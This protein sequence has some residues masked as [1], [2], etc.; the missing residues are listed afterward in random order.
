MPARKL[1][2][3]NIAYLLIVI[4]LS[5][6]LLF[7]GKS[8][9]LPL[10]FSLF[11]SM[12][13]YPLVK[14]IQKVVHYNAISIILTFFI[15]LIPLL[16]IAVFF[17]YQLLDIIDN[18][19]AIGNTIKSGF[20]KVINI[21]VDAV[22][23]GNM[24]KRDLMDNAISNIMNSPFEAIQGSL[25]STTG[26]LIGFGLTFIYTFFLLYYRVPIKAFIVFQFRESVRDEV[27][28]IIRSIQ[29]MSESYIIGIFFVILILSIL[30]T[31]GLYIIGIEYAIFWG[32]TA[33]LLAIIPYIGTALGGMLPFLFA[34]STTDTTWQPLAVIGYYIIIQ[35]VEGNF[36]TPKVVGDQVNI[37]P[38]VGLIG[39][40]FFGLFWG[41]AGVLLAIPLLAIIRIVFNHINITMPVGEMMGSGLNQKHTL[42]KEK[43]DDE[44]FSFVRYFQ[45]RK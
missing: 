10:I 34:L 26:I 2:I 44:K 5:G 21:I 14:R 6:F 1:P 19:P 33:G 37:N 38:F 15:V 11:L 7:I 17:S 22:P 20:S 16:L 40:T 3:Q 13:L 35:Q 31:I 8:F 18:M 12:M 4:I 27:R 39:I 43:Y 41:I 30:N 36:I 23:F 29:K 28:K 9:I 42:F 24:Q 45:T 25:S 32:V